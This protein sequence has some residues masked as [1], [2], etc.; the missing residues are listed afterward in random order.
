MGMHVGAGDDQ[1][2]VE[3]KYKKDVVFPRESN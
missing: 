3:A 2:P 1:F